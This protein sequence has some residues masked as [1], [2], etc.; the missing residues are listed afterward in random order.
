MANFKN[1]LRDK[2]NG[3]EHFN[4]IG[5][6]DTCSYGT[7]FRI[8]KSSKKNHTIHLVFLHALSREYINV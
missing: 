4:D 5:E 7:S 1:I 2:I 6:S 3:F 8:L